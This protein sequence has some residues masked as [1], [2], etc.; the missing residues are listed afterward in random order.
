MTHTTDNR[1][2]ITYTPASV[3]GHVE[4]PSAV[5]LRIMARLATGRGP[6]VVGRCSLVDG[7]RLH[8]GVAVVDDGAN[9][10]RTTRDI[11]LIVE[12]TEREVVDTPFTAPDV[13]E[14]E[15][16]LTVDGHVARA[17][18]PSTDTLRWRSQGSP[19]RWLMI[20]RTRDE[21]GLL[22][23]RILWSSRRPSR[24]IGALLA[25]EGIVAA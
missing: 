13:A 2:V 3:T 11:L 9:L 8:D 21:D 1:T 23:R 16:L 24:F 19:D 22:V 12:A 4:V 18:Q 14:G 17:T 15:P 25:S 5:A 20:T 6:Q 7:G 10:P